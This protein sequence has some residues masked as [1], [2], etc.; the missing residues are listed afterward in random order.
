MSSPFGDNITQANPLPFQRFS[1]DDLPSDVII[2][3]SRFLTFRDLNALYSVSKKLREATSNSLSHLLQFCYGDAWLPAMDLSR[4]RLIYSGKSF[5]IK[6]SESLG[7][8]TIRVFSLEENGQLRLFTV[9]ERPSEMLP[10][11]RAVPQ[12]TLT[13]KVATSNKERIEQLFEDYFSQEEL[14]EPE[15]TSNRIDELSTTPS[16]LKIEPSAR[17]DAK[18]EFKQLLDWIESTTRATAWQIEQLSNQLLAE[19]R[20]LIEKEWEGQPPC[21]WELRN[22]LKGVGELESLHSTLHAFRLH[23][24]RQL[25][26]S[27]ERHTQLY[28]P[29]GPIMH[30]F[31][32]FL[33]AFSRAFSRSTPL[34]ADRTATTSN[35]QPVAW[36]SFAL[37]ATGPSLSFKSDAL[38]H[39][40]DVSIVEG[41]NLPE[42]ELFYAR[43]SQAHQWIFYKKRHY[44]EGIGHNAL[45]PHLARVIATIISSTSFYSGTIQ[46][47]SPPGLPIDQLSLFG[48]ESTHQVAATS[49]GYIQYD[50][51][52]DCERL[53]QEL[54]QPTA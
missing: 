4:A 26:Y 13:D 52:M 39:R 50:C 3:L 44:Y 2:H 30:C 11:P 47:I 21:L 48:I 37:S 54:Q 7:E 31:S 24:S 10:S 8:T 20:T 43:Y 53:C 40:I 38:Q 32:R 12:E 35:P 16:H 23:N 22:R 36:P 1:L 19:R 28:D 46:I 15:T 41:G 5:S 17:L 42:K 29:A 6:E 33:K 34:V 51:I 18:T 25:A 9:T 49:P 45:A 14:L 27:K